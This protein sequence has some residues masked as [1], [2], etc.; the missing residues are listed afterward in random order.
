MFL[1]FGYGNGMDFIG[2]LNVQTRQW[3][4]LDFSLKLRI[5]NI[6]GFDQGNLIVHTEK[7][8]HFFKIPFG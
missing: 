3:N 5:E 6:T 4:I 8:H 2:C 7:K 1:R